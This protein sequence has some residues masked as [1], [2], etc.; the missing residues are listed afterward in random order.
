MASGVGF[1]KFRISGLDGKPAAL[2][3]GI[4]RID[5]KV[6]DRLFDL[7]GIGLHTMERRRRHYLQLDAG[8]N[9]AAQHLCHVHQNLI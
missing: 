9:E 6:H 2:G 7:S 8:R 5:R 3:H 4:V 1:V